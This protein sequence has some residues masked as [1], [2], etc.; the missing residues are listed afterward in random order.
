MPKLKLC[1][2]ETAHLSDELLHVD[3]LR[4][5]VMRTLVSPELVTNQL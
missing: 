4:V 1:Q 5:K 3:A 2:R